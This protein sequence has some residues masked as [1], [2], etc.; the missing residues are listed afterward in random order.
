MMQVNNEHFY[1]DLHPSL[2]KNILD[3][4]KNG[5][6]LKPGPQNEKRKNAEG[7]ALF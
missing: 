1:E 4:L 7:D 2:M 6:S 3:S 5:I